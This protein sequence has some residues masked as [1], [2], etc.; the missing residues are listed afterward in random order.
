MYAIFSSGGKQYRVKKGDTIRVD[1]LSSPLRSSKSFEEVLLIGL[2]DGVKVGQPLVPKAKVKAEVL[3]MEKGP[4]IEVFRKKR[5][6]QFKR[7]IGHRQAYTRL[8]ITEVHDGE[9][10]DS[11]SDKE[12]KSILSRIAFATQDAFSK[13]DVDKKNEG[14]RAKTTSKVKQAA[15]SK[16]RKATKT[17]AE[18]TEKKTKK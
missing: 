10:S 16:A 2:G 11:L 9:S 18:K 14:V 17:P 1:A 7:H 4:K 8:L 6:K 3:A 15:V 5:R 13:P 12:K